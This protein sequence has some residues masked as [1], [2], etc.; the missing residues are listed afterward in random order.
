M[1]LC[2]RLT[3]SF[4][5]TGSWLDVRFNTNLGKSYAYRR[6]RSSRLSWVNP[7]PHFPWPSPTHP[8]VPH[9]PGVTIPQGIWS[10]SASR[11]P[12]SPL[13]LL[14]QWVWV[15]VQESL[16]S[17]CS[18]MILTIGKFGEAYFLIP[19]TAKLI[20]SRF[21]W[22]FIHLYHVDELF[23]NYLFTYLFSLVDSSLLICFGVASVWHGVLNSVNA[24]G[25]PW[26]TMTAMWSINVSPLGRPKVTWQ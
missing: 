12:A 7:F 16:S 14:T 8:G 11:F 20:T 9:N 4:R 3:S 23:C 15:G 10:A 17:Q 22:H 25:H 19:N 6:W 5:I 2:D 1:I 26:A 21:P 13:D 18:R 24:Q